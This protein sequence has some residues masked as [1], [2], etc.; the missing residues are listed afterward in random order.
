MGQSC[1]LIGKYPSI[2]LVVAI[3]SILHIGISIVFAFILLAIEKDDIYRTIYPYLLFSYMWITWT[4]SYVVYTTIAG[5][6]ASWYFLSGTDHMPDHPVWDSLKRSC[7]TSFGSNA[8][9]AMLVAVIQLLTV[10]ASTPDVKGS[11]GDVLA[12]LK[13]VAKCLLQIFQCFVTWINRYGLIYCAIFGVPYREGCRR[14]VE[15]SCTRFAEVI[16]SG[17]C[18]GI[19]LGYN[20]VI[21]VVGTGLLGFGVGFAITGNIAPAGALTLA[22]A[23]LF[24]YG[25]FEILSKPI[26]T[27]SDTL[28]L[29][30]M[31]APAQMN[32]TASE[33]AD[34]FNECYSTELAL[35]VQQA[36]ERIARLRAKNNPD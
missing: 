3:E 7:T 23:L 19:A 4:F 32:S 35:R 21:F 1:A 5:T 30:F 17:T 36:E 34:R 28:L 9:A 8:F 25:V 31:E 26:I 22:F 11:A 6:A 29:C 24:A 14:W 2:I 27:M 33:L 20:E 15:L 10:L 18:I 13:V 12:V 16:C